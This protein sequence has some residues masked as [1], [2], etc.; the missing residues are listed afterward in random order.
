MGFFSTTKNTENKYTSSHSL[1]LLCGSRHLAAYA[2]DLDCLK[3][4]NLNNDPDSCLRR[5]DQINCSDL[6]DHDSK[7][8]TLRAL[9]GLS[10]P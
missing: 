1:C 6:Y 8:K 4:C 2:P 5:N 7:P 3:G 9:C 10:F